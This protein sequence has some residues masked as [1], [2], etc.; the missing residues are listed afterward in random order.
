M[1][2][3]C[4]FLVKNAV[5]SRV[6]SFHFIAIPRIP[7]RN[8]SAEA[9]GAAAGK[10]SSVDQFLNPPEGLVFGRVTG[11]GVGKNT[12]KSDIIHYFE[13]CNLSAG[14]V[15]VEY[16][17]SYNPVALMLQFPSQSAYDTALRQVIRKGRL[18]KIEK[19]NRT[20]WDFV[21][22]Y[23]GKAILL[24]GIPRNALPDDIERFLSGTNYDPNFQPSI[25]L[26]AIDSIRFALV[27]F[28]TRPDAMNAFL[29]RN[30]SFCLNS[31][32]IMRLL[33]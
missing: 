9:E 20:M 32:I 2:K 10:D 22:A 26:G 13:G 19:V 15:K 33:Q 29:T 31:P 1:S 3:L 6:S 27:Q 28:P 8:F 5:K 12:T 30:K 25:R 23:D 14:D 17:R 16:N 18:Y 4:F 21:A 7:F 24:Q 11:N